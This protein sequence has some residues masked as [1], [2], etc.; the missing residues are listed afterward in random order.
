MNVGVLGSGMVGQTLGAGFAAAGHEVMLGTRDP[1]GAKAMAWASKAGPRAR[2]GT[3][4]EAAAF[5]DVAILATAWDGTESAIG[6]AGPA[7]LAGKIVMDTTNPLRFAPNAPPTLAVG[8]TDSAGERVQR[9]LPESKVVKVFNTVGYAHMV[10]PDFPGGP[11]DLLLC[12][13]DEDAKR[14]V[15]TLCGELGWPIIDLGGIESA[16]YLEPFAMVWILHMIRSGSPGHAFK[17]LRK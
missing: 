11:P 17:L 7:R 15:A 9:W 5:G 4:A 6:L 16:R 12:G 8:H 3:F 14:S 2:A 1:G 10:R 13:D